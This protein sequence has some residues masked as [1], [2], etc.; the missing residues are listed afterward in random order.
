MDSQQLAD[1]IRPIVFRTFG[2]TNK[3]HVEEFSVAFVYKTNYDEILASNSDLVK[4]AQM[5][6]KHGLTLGLSSD[7]AQE[8]TVR[9]HVDQ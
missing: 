9:L 5:L 1:L 7:R 6:N 3:V 8:V 2:R 4:L